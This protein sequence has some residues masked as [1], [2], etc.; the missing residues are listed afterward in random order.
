M[1]NVAFNCNSIILWEKIDCY[2]Y[3]LKNINSSGLPLKVRVTNEYLNLDS[4][5]TLDHEAEAGITLPSDGIFSLTVEVVNGGTVVSTFRDYLYEFCSL[6]TCFNKLLFNVYSDCNTVIK[7][8][9]AKNCKELVV[10]EETR[11][12]SRE[13]LEELKSMLLL[14]FSSTGLYREYYSF[15]KINEMSALPNTLMSVKDSIVSVYEKINSFTKSCGFTCEPQD[16]SCNK[17]ND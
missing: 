3:N 8:P 7:D 1:E 15:L 14:L 11:K 6:Q 13:A 5:I 9:C 16:D 10:D 2:K 12:K 4:T 17:C